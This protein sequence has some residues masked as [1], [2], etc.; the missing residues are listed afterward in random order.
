MNE[1]LLVIF[2]KF[3]GLIKIKMHSSVYSPEKG[4]TALA[5]DSHYSKRRAASTQL[6]HIN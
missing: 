5:V 6:D 1:V 2:L 4:S 3:N